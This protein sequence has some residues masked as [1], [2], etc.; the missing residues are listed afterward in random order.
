MKK[1]VSKDGLT[2]TTAELIAI[3]EDYFYIAIPFHYEKGVPIVS[4]LSR[5]EWDIQEAKR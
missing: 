2:R 5:S 4:T 1:F 3:D